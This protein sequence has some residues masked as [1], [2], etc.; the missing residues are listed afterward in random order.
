M[1]NEKRQ[2]AIPT[3]AALLLLVIFAVSVL[4]VLLAGAGVYSRLTRRDERAYDSRTGLQY[5]ASRVRQATVPG[6][7]Q[8][9]QFGGVDALSVREQVDGE[10]YVTRIYCHEGWLMELFCA[11]DAGLLPEDGERLLPA[12]SLELELRDGLLYVRLTQ[13]EAHELILYPQWGEG[14]QP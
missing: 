4:G 8:V 14:A 13:E 1:M 10:S 11:A 6:G 5:V 7:V 9:E 3:L 12:R 2:Q